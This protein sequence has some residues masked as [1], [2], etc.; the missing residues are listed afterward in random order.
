M[1]SKAEKQRRR[2]IVRDIRD[3]EHSEVEARMPISKPDLRDL[4]EMLDSTLFERRDGRT[5]CRCDHSLR[6]TREF[7]RSRNLAEDA[8]VSW[9]GE[10]GGY[11]DCEVAANV[12]DYWAEHVGYD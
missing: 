10:Y 8:I 5:W 1:P 11:C 2:A 3:T 7:L 4:L 9:L 12:S 6:R